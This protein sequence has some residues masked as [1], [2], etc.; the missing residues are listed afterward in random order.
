[1]ALPIP[2]I[3]IFVILFLTT[4]AVGIYY[5]T[6][7]STSPQ[8]TSSSSSSTTDGSA[9]SDPDA[10]YELDISGG[11]GGGGGI[12]STNYPSSPG[13][14]GD[15]TPYLGPSSTSPPVPSYY[16]SSSSS[17]SSQSSSSD[18]D[19]FTPS[20][21]VSYT[22]PGYSA[23]PPPAPTFTP[24]IQEPEP[25]P[26]K[27][28]ADS[29]EQTVVIEQ[30]QE[31]MGDGGGGGGSAQLVSK[32]SALDSFVQTLSHYLVSPF[33]QT[34]HVPLE[35]CATQCLDQAQCKSFYHDVSQAEQCSLN[36]YV[37]GDYHEGAKEILALTP[38][39]SYNYYQK[40]DA[41]ITYFKPVVTDSYGT[42][43]SQLTK[44]RVKTD[45]Y[46]LKDTKG[47][48]ELMT[49]P[50]NAMQVRLVATGEP[51]EYYLLTNFDMYMVLTNLNDVS[52]SY[53]K[54]D[55]AKW[56]V[57]KFN[58]I[59]KIK[60]KVVG[61]SLAAEGNRAIVNDQGDSWFLIAEGEVDPS[62]EGAAAPEPT[63][64]PAPEPTPTLTTTTTTTTTQERST[65]PYT[66]AYMDNQYALEYTP[67]LRPVMYKQFLHVDSG[68]NIIDLTGPTEK[69]TLITFNK[70]NNVNTYAIKLGDRYLR[71]DYGNLS[72][73]EFIQPYEQLMWR[74]EKDPNQANVYALANANAYLYIRETTKEYVVGEYQYKIDYEL[75]T[76]SSSAVASLDKY[77]LYRWIMD[78]ITYTDPNAP[79]PEPVVLKPITEEKTVIQL[80]QLAADRYAKDNAASGMTKKYDVGMVVDGD[81]VD[82]SFIYEK[83]GVFNHIDARRYNF[84]RDSNNVVIYFNNDGRNS[85]LKVLPTQLTSQYTATELFQYAKAYYL[86]N[87]GSF[88]ALD[89]SN[90]VDALTVDYLFTD[91]SKGYQLRRYVFKRNSGTGAIEV[92]SQGA[93]DS[94]ATLIQYKP[95]VQTAPLFENGHAI[96]V[97]QNMYG[98]Y[99]GPSQETNMAQQSVYDIKQALRMAF[100]RTN[101]NTVG[102]RWYDMVD[103]Q[104]QYI[105]AESSRLVS[106]SNEG[107]DPGYHWYVEESPNDP[108]SVKIKGS[109]GNWLVWGSNGTTWTLA[110]TIPK[111]YSQ[112]WNLVKVGT[113]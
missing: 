106:I 13:G 77:G 24:E 100:I 16:S 79:P 25:V 51:D 58:S 41:K 22:P 91:A 52:V 40:K 45:I 85:G 37:P 30:P 89:R 111:G 99:V 8:D 88:A 27:S 83:N 9:I 65:T 98:T 71:S 50:T 66:T 64:T 72:L 57:R 95:V 42:D 53:T 56:I 113:T 80:A 2:V 92:A 12:S 54:S 48:V 101:P 26:S 11:G 90:P 70:A 61:L 67:P 68:S 43:V 18:N 15:L 6:A 97:L 59:Y 35:Q 108:L 10:D 55:R 110:S 112:M 93:Q 39:S 75:T 103:P 49:T 14:L 60:H 36:Q 33:S 94:A 84:A 32:P 19:T 62:P 47:P 38:S 7:P 29:V 78:N 87:G 74:I 102:D 96:Y 105:I 28:M 23:P 34:D 63:P 31:I 109:N 21:P 76:G 73:T 1:M 3:A 46:Y 81:S 86:A 4:V 5:V 17:S 44:Y 107:G 69:A 20:Q 82:I 104:G